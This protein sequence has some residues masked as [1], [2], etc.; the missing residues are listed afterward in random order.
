MSDEIDRAQAYEEKARQAAL[1]E[2]ARRADGYASRVSAV[3][4]VMCD[5][6]IAAARRRALPG[7]QT[8]IDCQ[9]DIES[10]GLYDWG[11]HGN[12]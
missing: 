2:H 9:R 12:P 1:A 5:E 4:C 11:S 3:E 7:V 10:A 8:C 6:P